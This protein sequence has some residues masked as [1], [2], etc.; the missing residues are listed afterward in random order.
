MQLDK[1]HTSAI[2]E[3]VVL[4]EQLLE[5]GNGPGLVC[6]GRSTCVLWGMGDGC[7]DV[8][9][10][11]VFPRHDIV[12]LGVHAVDVSL[13][14]VAVVDDEEAGCMG[15]CVSVCGRMSL[16][17]LNPNGSFQEAKYGNK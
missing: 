2:G 10:I 5:L 3:V 12:V 14:S 6:P 4:C 8:D 15:S 1:T 11:L 7:K 9:E 16:A 17:F 13:D